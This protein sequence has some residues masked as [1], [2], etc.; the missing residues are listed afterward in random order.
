MTPTTWNTLFTQ[1]FISGTKSRTKLLGSLRKHWI[2]D[3]GMKDVETYDALIPDIIEDSRQEADRGF[4]PLFQLY[5]VSILD[6]MERKCREAGL[7]I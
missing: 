5:K 3:Y 6:I 7:I 1:A 2:T 4:C